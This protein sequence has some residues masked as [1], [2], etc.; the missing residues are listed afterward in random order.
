MALLDDTIQLS[1]GTEPM[2]EDGLEEED[3]ENK[4]QDIAFA[5]LGARGAKP[6]L[7]V[8]SVF[9]NFCLIDPLSQE[10]TSNI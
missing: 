2:S 9:P 1:T 6:H 4:V 5:H 8:G 10:V 3:E 7:F